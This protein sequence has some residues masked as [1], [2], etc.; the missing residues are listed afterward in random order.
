MRVYECV[1]CVCSTMYAQTCAHG[2][3]RSQHLL[4]S[5]IAFH[6]GVSL[7]RSLTEAGAH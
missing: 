5:S 6:T 4:S 3:F 2:S 7:L 1:E